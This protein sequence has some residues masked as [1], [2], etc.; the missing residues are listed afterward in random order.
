[1]KAIQY[2]L[3]AILFIALSIA[4]S[5]AQTRQTEVA[6]QES[7]QKSREA[8]RAAMR[9]PVARQMHRNFLKHTM[10]S[11]WNDEATSQM[12]IA[13]LQQ[14]AFREALGVSKE[15]SQKMLNAMQNI[16]TTIQTNPETKPLF[17]EILK[18]HTETPEGPYAETTSE[19][20]QKKLLDLQMKMQDITFKITNDIVNETLTPEQLKKIREFQISTMSRVPLVSPNMFEALDLSDDQK[21]QLDDIKK[22]MEPDFEKHLD[23]FVEVQSKYSEIFQ[24]EVD[25]KLDG[26]VDPEERYR[27]HENITKTVYGSNPEYQREIREVMESGK[28]FANKLKFRMFDV[29]TDEQMERMADFIDNP[30]DYVKNAVADIYQGTENNDSSNGEWKPNLNSWKPGDPIPEEYLEQRKERKKN[31]PKKQ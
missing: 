9:S 28:A 1:M 31:F 16:G 29:L 12:A 22:E 23:K 2:G 19:E 26:V 17:E 10:R 7:V 11:F 5:S 20:K 14:D 4:F 24:N 8:E 15:Q 25:E 30:P 3:T 13:V 27:I 18:W 6:K 21:K